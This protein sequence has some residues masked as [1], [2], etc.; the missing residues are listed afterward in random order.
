[1]KGYRFST[2]ISILRRVLVDDGLQMTPGAPV[3]LCTV[4]AARRDIS[5]AERFRA[6]E[7]AAEMVARFVVRSTAVTRDISAKDTLKTDAGV[8]L[9]IIGVKVIQ[10]GM[11]IEITTAARSDT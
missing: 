11:L 7:K 4:W 6:G 10:E 1:M 2:R 9:E 8:E 3:T 5:D